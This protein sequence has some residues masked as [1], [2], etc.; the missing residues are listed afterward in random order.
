MKF[1]ILIFALFGITLGKTCPK[2]YPF[3]LPLTV[4]NC[5]LEGCKSVEMYDSIQEAKF[6]YCCC[7]EDEG[8]FPLYSD[9]K[10]LRSYHNK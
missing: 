3:Y 7:I 10:N 2:D 4:S 9:L 5:T 6:Y 1:L 8:L